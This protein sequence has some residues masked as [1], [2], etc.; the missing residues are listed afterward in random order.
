MEK[1]I[2]KKLVI[3]PGTMLTRPG[4][5]WASIY[6]SIKLTE[7]GSLSISGVIGPLPSGNALGACGQIDMEFHHRNPDHNHK[8]YDN[9][10]KPRDIRFRPGWTA[11]KWLQFLED[12]RLYHLNDMQPGCEHQTAENW[13][14]KRIKLSAETKTSGWVHPEEHPDG[15]LTKPCPT[16]GYEY[17]TAWNKSEVPADVLAWLFQLP[18]ADQTPAWV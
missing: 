6:C 1:N 16:C 18:P 9:P 10:I 7:D 14:H 8:R 5:R 12:W 4:G 11:T 15:E 13:G 17:G 2:E 3:R